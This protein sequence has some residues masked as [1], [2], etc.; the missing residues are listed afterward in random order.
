MNNLL[1]GIKTYFLRI[2]CEIVLISDT[3]LTVLERIQ[4]FIKSLLAFAPIAFVLNALEM[5]FMDNTQFTT[6]VIAVVLINMLLGAYTHKKRGTFNWRI[7][8][9]KTIMMVF[10]I[11]ITYIVL[12]L[13]ISRAG[14]NFIV[15]GFRSA[16]QVA[17]LL[18][19]G[20]KILKNVFILS[21]GEYPPKWIMQKIYNFEENGDLTEFLA[22]PTTSEPE[23]L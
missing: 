14:D 5:W 19:P 8:I 18:Y 2:Y 17:T 21:K 15:E 6:G 11:N 10:L 13:I 16:L 20:S 3:N 4:H 23:E 12:E 22:S 1:I 9:S 7:F